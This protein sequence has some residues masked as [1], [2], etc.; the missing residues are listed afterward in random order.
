MSGMI[1][2]LFRA[3]LQDGV[4]RGSR[5][6]EGWGGRSPPGDRDEYYGEMADFVYRGPLRSGHSPPSPSAKGDGG[7]PILDRW[8]ELIR[9]R[10]QFNLSQP[11]R[12]QRADRGPD[13]HPQPD[14]EQRYR[15]QRCHS[16]HPKCSLPFCSIARRWPVI[17]PSVDDGISLLGRNLAVHRDLPLAQ[18][19][20]VASRAV[21]TMIRH[22]GVRA[23][24]AKRPTHSSFA[25]S[26]QEPKFEVANLLCILTHQPLP[27][28]SRPVPSTREVSA[29]CRPPRSRSPS[30]PSSCARFFG[31]CRSA[32]PSIS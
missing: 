2:S 3:D 24:S 14:R 15:G 28:V 17:R 8:A 10:C 21:L 13:R 16:A 12:S 7:Q 6:P 18:T 11:D 31:N 5:L 22:P 20:A 9:R 4:D 25:A 23:A 29:S 30:V 1:F 32:S 19:P 27:A 26:T